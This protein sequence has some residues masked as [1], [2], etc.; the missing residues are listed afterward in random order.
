MSD[1]WKGSPWAEERRQK[2]LNKRKAAEV[3]KAALALL[4]AGR[5]RSC[6][7]ECHQGRTPHSGQ[8]CACKFG[9]RR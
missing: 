7:C 9:A 1:T 2:A 3:H 5:V 8:K 4:R 6:P